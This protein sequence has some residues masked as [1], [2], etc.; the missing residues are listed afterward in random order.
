MVVDNAIFD[1]TYSKLVS[2]ILIK[3]NSI[4]IT[5][6][7][8]H[9]TDSTMIKKLN[10]YIVYLDNVKKSPYRYRYVKNLTGIVNYLNTI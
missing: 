9:R 8:G 1:K 4:K 5:R 7:Q 3:L 6:Q 2:I 10:L